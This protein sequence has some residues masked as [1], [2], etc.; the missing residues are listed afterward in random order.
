MK[1]HNIE[2]DSIV[3]GD[4][5]RVVLWVSGCTHR[6]KKCQNPITWNSKYGID[7]GEDELNEIREALSKSYISGITFSGGDPLHPYNRNDIIDLSKLLRKEFPNK[8]QWLYTGFLWDDILNI[9]GIENI[10]VLVDG[11]FIYPLRDKNYHWAGSTNQRVIDVKKSLSA[12][13]VVLYESN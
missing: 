5:L 13:K 6:C 1:Y 4:G 8:T 11:K 2:K 3:N 9:N 12:K 10:D 7:F